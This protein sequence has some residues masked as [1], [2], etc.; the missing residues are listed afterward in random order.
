MFLYLSYRKFREI[1]FSDITQRMVLIVILHFNKRI[2]VSIIIHCHKVDA[3]LDDN[4]KRPLLRIV[5]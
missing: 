2:T 3:S 5:A 1:S 4:R